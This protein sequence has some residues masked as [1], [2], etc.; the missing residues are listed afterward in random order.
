M[1][2]RDIFIKMERDKVNPAKIKE[3]IKEE[4]ARLYQHAEYKKVIVV[5]DV[6]P[7]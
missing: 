6:D 1:Y 5:M 4:Q 2:L 3:V 7:Y